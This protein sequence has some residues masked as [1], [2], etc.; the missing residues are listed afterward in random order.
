[1]TDIYARVLRV[2]E[3]SEQFECSL[4]FTSIDPYGQKAVQQFVDRAVA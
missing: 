2:T 1:V 4:E 3:A